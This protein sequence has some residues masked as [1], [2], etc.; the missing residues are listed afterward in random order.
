MQSQGCMQIWCLA[1]TKVQRYKGNTCFSNSVLDIII[2]W[3][4]LLLQDL[5]TV[6][7]AI[8]IIYECLFQNIPSLIDFSDHF[9]RS[10]SSCKHRT[11]EVPQA[12]LA[13]FWYFSKN[14]SLE[15]DSHITYI[16]IQWNVWQ[17]QLHGKA[18]FRISFYLLDS[19]PLSYI[20]RRF[21]NIIITATLTPVSG[22]NKL[23]YAHRQTG[24]Y[25]IN[26]TFVRSRNKW[27][28]DLITGWLPQILQWG[29]YIF[30]GHHT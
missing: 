23:T 9:L 26:P 22:T 7:P 18:P 4:A 10:G 1:A 19:F 15:S 8:Y 3:M 6:C 20:S 25:L 28:E 27:F 14:A 17:T 11:H 2:L 12:I 5:R 21:R 24:T 29:A 30:I 13:L 16:K